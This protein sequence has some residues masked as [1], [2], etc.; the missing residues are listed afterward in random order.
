MVELQ[1]L[2]NDAWYVTGRPLTSLIDGKG[3]NSV[4][5]Y[6]PA[7]M[8]TGTPCTIAP[9]KVNSHLESILVGLISCPQ[10]LNSDGLELPEMI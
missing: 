4:T 10:P 6:L 8:A 2:E 1:S 7:T 9:F 3:I 5:L